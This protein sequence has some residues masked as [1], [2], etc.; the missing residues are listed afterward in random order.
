MDCAVEQGHCLL[1]HPLWPSHTTHWVV[2]RNQH[3]FHLSN[4][5]M[6]VLTS[7]SEPSLFPHIPVGSLSPLFPTGLLPLSL[8]FFLHSAYVSILKTEAARS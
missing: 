2:I 7:A 1:F 3:V 6:A 5:A 8:H 4:V